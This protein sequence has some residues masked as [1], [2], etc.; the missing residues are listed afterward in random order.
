MTSGRGPDERSELRRFVR[1]AAGD[2]AEVAIIWLLAVGIPLLGLVVFVLVLL[3]R[4]V[5]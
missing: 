4:S 1:G 2:L 3:V 5:L